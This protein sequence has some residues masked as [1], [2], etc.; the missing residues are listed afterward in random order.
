MGIADRTCPTCHKICAT[1]ANLKT[2]MNRKKGCE[3]ETV[4]SLPKKYKCTRCDGL[5]QTRQ[6]LTLHI[7]RQKQCIIKDDAVLT[8]EQL[9]QEVKNQKILIEQLQLSREVKNQNGT[10]NDL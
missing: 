1:K 10:E 7:N 8:L 5:F 3:D 2:H 6:N 4:V 9:T